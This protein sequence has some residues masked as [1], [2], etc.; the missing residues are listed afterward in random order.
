[1]K[2][3]IIKICFALFFLSYYVSEIN[4]NVTNK[5]KF[6]L[7]NYFTKNEDLNNA[8]DNENVHGESEDKTVTG[9]DQTTLS[10]TS[11]T[12][13]SGSNP[14]DGG[15]T[16]IDVNL[17]KNGHTE[18]SYTECEIEC[19]EDCD[20][21]HDESCTDCHDESCTDCH[22]ESCPDCQTECTDACREECERMRAS[23]NHCGGEGI[24]NCPQCTVNDPNCE[25]G[26]DDNQFSS[27]IQDFSQDITEYALMEDDI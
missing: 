24:Q 17:P 6:S 10:G 9:T 14:Q 26:I 23:I 16:S 22:D 12:Q 20:E 5:N 21:C 13:K 25:D 19:T 3:N 27:D 18:Q 7:R 8:S 2:N 11:D 4:G 1:M 15:V